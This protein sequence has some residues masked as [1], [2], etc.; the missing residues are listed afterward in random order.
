M[1]L[2][3]CNHIAFA[4]VIKSFMLFD[5]RV[6]YSEFF[7]EREEIYLFFF[8]FF[9]FK[10]KKHSPTKLNPF[11]IK[12]GEKIHFTSLKFEVFFNFNPNV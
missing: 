9:F 6:L 7:M 5:V 10:K 12:K 11:H 1:Y 4:Y 2:R 3:L 8:F